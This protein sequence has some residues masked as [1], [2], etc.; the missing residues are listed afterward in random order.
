MSLRDLGRPREALAHDREGL[1]AYASINEPDPTD[2]Y[3][4]ALACSRIWAL[5]DPGSDEEREKLQSRAVTYLRRAIEGDPDRYPAHRIATS[6]SFR[7][8]R[9]RADYQGMLADAI[10]PRNPFAQAS[11]IAQTAIKSGPKTLEAG[12]ADTIASRTTPRKVPLAAGHTRETMPDL[13]AASAR[14][15]ADTELLIKVAA[16]QA[17]FGK[18]ADLAVTWRR[19][20][21]FARGTQEPMTAER[22][23]KICSLRP[24]NDK[25]HLDATLALARQAVKLGADDPYLP[26]YRMALG[27][28]EY[29]SG[30]YAAAEESLKA[31]ANANERNGYVSVTSGFYLAMS[32]FR[33]GKEDEARRMMKAAAAEMRPLPADEDKPLSDLPSNAD[34]L[35]LWMAY[36]EAKALIGFESARTAPTRSPPNS[37]K[38]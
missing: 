37:E 35:I 22:T 8:L 15:P 1:A 34:D 14:N 5:L 23:A 19:A 38:P 4:M 25:A 6:S 33:Q 31:G 18:D 13:E 10:F 20:L 32:Q 21:E 36:K 27:M 28:A 30:N 7:R 9:D 26:Y 29:R 17:W 2:S 11:P 24:S 3:S 12:D 16:L